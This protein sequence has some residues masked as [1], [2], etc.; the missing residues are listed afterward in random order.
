MKSLLQC[1]R[2]AAAVRVDDCGDGAVLVEAAAPDR[3]SP[4]QRVSS[5]GGRVREG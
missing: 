2:T 4:E 1:Y 5:G 3:P